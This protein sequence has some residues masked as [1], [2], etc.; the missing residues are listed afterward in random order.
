MRLDMSPF[1]K[2]NMAYSLTAMYYLEE[3]WEEQISPFVIMRI[4]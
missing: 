1:M 2:K 3:A 4:S